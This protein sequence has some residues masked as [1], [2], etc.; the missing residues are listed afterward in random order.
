MSL[1]L[2]QIT[3]E[4]P[5]ST[6]GPRADGQSGSRMVHALAWTG[7]A[8]W[9]T[10][11]ITWAYMIVVARVLTPAD[12]GLIGM[13]NVPLGF[14]MVASEFGVGNAV[15]MM[16]RLTPGQLSQLNTVAVGT[17][18]ILFV[19][20]CCGAYALGEFFRAPALPVVIVVLSLALVISSFKIIPQG[21]L[22]RELRFKLLAQINTAEAVAYGC[23]AVI[24]IVLGAG[25]WSLVIANLASAML[26]TVFIV[27]S[28]PHTFA[29]PKM[30]DLR[31]SLVF[32]AHVFGRRIAWYY[33]SN[34]DFAVAGRVLGEAALGSY[35]I[36]WNIAEQPQ[37]KFSDLVA[38]VLPPYFTRV[39]DD[40]AALREYVLRITEAVSL[41]TLPA[42]LGMALV[43]EDFILVVLGAKWISAAVPLRILLAY[44]A[45][46]SLTSYFAPLLNI[47]GH[48]RFV[49]WN[50][51]LGAFYFTAAFY[52]ASR[53]GVLGIALVWPLLYPV[54]AIPLYVRV[55][56]DLDL[57]VRSYVSS[58]LPA[59]SGLVIML[60]SVLI[61]RRFLS[62]NEIHLQLALEVATGTMA[63]CTTVAALFSRQLRVLYTQIRP[64]IRKPVLVER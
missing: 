58:L 14:L 57:S 62:I 61:L 24:S 41:V 52:F 48:S 8:T 53:W 56:Q 55:F 34:I 17:G 9:T 6:R 32:S 59:L 40:T 60:A 7:A 45:L 42:Y 28:R 64:I 22:Q 50:H 11:L 12:Y 4:N 44:A 35:N 25:Y 43:A 47:R 23:S 51:I 13:A 38:R 5:S 19:F 10:Q 31:N 16:P 1:D 26:A 39:H 30:A 46:R 3:R 20:S 29:L 49:M 21:L 33:N 15:V 63:Y 27:R 2:A 37:Q 54:L 18:I 36:A